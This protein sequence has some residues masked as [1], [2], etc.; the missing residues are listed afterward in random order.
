[1][2]S[3]QQD[4]SPTPRQAGLRVPRLH[5]QVPQ[6]LPR[7]GGAALPA[8]HRAQHGAVSVLLLHFF[9]FF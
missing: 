6:A 5:A 4:D 1:M 3:V 2:R 7:A 8:L 9:R